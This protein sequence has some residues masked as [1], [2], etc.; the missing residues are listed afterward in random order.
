M[1]N[2]KYIFIFFYLI[3]YQ[4]SLSQLDSLNQKDTLGKKQGYWIVYGI[5]KPEKNYCDTCQVE[6]GN[7]L[8]NQKNGKWVM[9]QKDGITPKLIGFYING[10]PTGEFV[11][12]RNVNSK[13]AAGCPKSAL[14]FNKN[15]KQ[16]G[17]S[18]L[19][20]DCDSLHPNLGQIQVKYKMDNGQK[21]D[22]LFRY[23]RNGDLKQQIIYKTDHTIQSKQNFKRVSPTIEMDYTELIDSNNLCQWYFEEEV[24]FE[25]ECKNGKIWTGKKYVYDSDGILLKI[26]I[27]KEG[28]FYLLGEL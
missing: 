12:I 13:Y 22:T 18:F 6:E 27:W 19:Y 9:Y 16:H 14:K 23:Y 17:V 11:R 1:L 8:N 15:G 10:R 28:I 26:E 5:D 24:L 7:Y 25:G 20:Y 3:I 4:V 2:L 21:I